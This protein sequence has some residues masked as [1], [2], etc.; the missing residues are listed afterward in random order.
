M[1]ADTPFD[2]RKEVLNTGEE[3]VI[4]ASPPAG[5]EVTWNDWPS[6]VVFTGTLG[7]GEYP[8]D[9]AIGTITD[10]PTDYRYWDVVITAE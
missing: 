6:E 3:L 9:V 10:G 2:Y 1:T 4:E 7:A 5:V 8:F